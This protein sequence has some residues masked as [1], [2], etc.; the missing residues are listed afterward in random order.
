MSYLNKYF[1]LIFLSFILALI[2]IYPFLSAGFDGDLAVYQGDFNYYAK[3]FS[4]N[5][6]HR[7]FEGGIIILGY[8]IS[9]LTTDFF[10]FK[11]LIT[12]FFY[13][14]LLL[15]V[16]KNII[17]KKNLTILGIIILLTFPFYF[18]FNGL[19]DVA[20]RQGL[21][22]LILLAFQFPIKE[23]KLIS[24]I[25]IISLASYFHNSA[26]IFLVVFFLFK[27]CNNTKYYILFFII[28]SALYIFDIPLLF[29]DFLK[30]VIETIFKFRTNLAI[31]AFKEK[32]NYGFHFYKFV[33]LF[34]PFL[35][36]LVFSKASIFKNNHYKKIFNLYMFFSGLSFLMSGLPYHDRVM[37]FAWVWLP[38]LLLPICE[39]ILIQISNKKKN[40]N[41][42]F[43]KDKFK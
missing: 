5:E 11:F 7:K 24:A 16:Y 43:L 36:L 38:I 23:L 32:L 29:T 26:L 31:L 17:Y 39:I 42:I 9:I 6:I 12:F 20:L 3:N 34:L 13:Y 37:L 40:V 4:I 41:N 33:S 10:M 19:T 2:N 30:T 25:F 1:F 15:I 27:I 8:L 18:A 28:S 22:I 35:V 14:F 21:S